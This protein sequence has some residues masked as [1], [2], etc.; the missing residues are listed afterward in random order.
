M[1][2]VLAMIRW[3]W[4]FRKTMSTEAGD[5]Q[6]INSNGNNRTCCCRKKRGSVLCGN[7]ASSFYLSTIIMDKDTGRGSYIQKKGPTG[8]FFVILRACPVDFPGEAPLW[9]IVSPNQLIA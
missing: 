8:T 9:H 7:R 5:R 3:W 6:R 1:S 4:L 2:A